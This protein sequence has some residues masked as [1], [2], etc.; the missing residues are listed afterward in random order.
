MCIAI[1]KK[2]G[3]KCPSL[4][5]LHNCWESNPDGAGFAFNDAGRVVIKKGFMT[6]GDFKTAWLRYSKRYDFDN[7]GVLIHFRI[8]THGGTN[9]QNTHP[10]PVISDTGMMQKS[11]CVCDYAAIHNGVI[12]LTSSQ[13]YKEHTV[14]DTLVFIRDYL[15][16]IAQNKSWFKR[17]SNIE[18]IDLLIDAPSSKMAILNGRGEII[19]TNG[20]IEDNGV[21]YSNQSY[22]VA[23][24]RSTGK[25]YGSYIPCYDDDFEDDYYGREYGYNGY[26]TGYNSGYNNGYGWG[27]GSNSYYQNGQRKSFNTTSASAD[28]AQIPLMRCAVGN[29]V[30]CECYEDSYIESS[31][32]R[33]FCISKEGYV[34]ELADRAADSMA[35][36]EGYDL[37]FLGSGCFFDTYN[38][39]IDFSP[40]FYAYPGQ[41]MSDMTPDEVNSWGEYSNDPDTPPVEEADAP[42]D[43]INLNMQDDKKKEGADAQG[44]GEKGNE[45]TATK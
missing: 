39:K 45:T 19:Y 24:V 12:S 31:K 17:R 25:K 20:F 4:D 9:P 44:N 21:L 2:I 35:G 29:T 23:R 18:L 16:L 34:Y 42:D 7:R 33:N 43:I 5:T 10:F 38:R 30:R 8:S 26:G 15:S 11:E 22:K 36:D 3:S 14:S 13:A 32:D 6:W 27:Y 41:F 1:A 40:N 28:D 37:S